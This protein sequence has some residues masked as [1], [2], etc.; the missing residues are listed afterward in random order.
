MRTA[1]SRAAKTFSKCHGSVKRPLNRPL[2]S[3]AFVEPRILGDTSTR[4]KLTYPWQRMQKTSAGLNFSSLGLPIADRVDLSL[5]TQGNK[6]DFDS[7]VDVLRSRF[8]LSL[9]DALA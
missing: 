1:H 9:R 2:V 5:Y 3:C 4:I 7:F 6:R 8:E